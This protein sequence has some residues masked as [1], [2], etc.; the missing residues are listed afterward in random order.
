MARVSVRLTDAFV[1][2]RVRAGLTQEDVA[3]KIGTGQAHVSRRESGTPLRLRTAAAML[4][5]LGLTIEEGIEGGLVEVIR[6]GKMGAAH[7]GAKRND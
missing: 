5:V 4:G 6:N 2:A 7:G 3:A 1:E